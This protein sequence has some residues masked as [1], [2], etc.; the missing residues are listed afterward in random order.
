MSEVTQNDV[1]ILYG[2]ASPER[3]AV[4]AQKIA[5]N[6]NSETLSET[7]FELA[8][9]ICQKLADDI[10]ET[11]R[12]SLSQ[13]LKNSTDIPKELA[14]K[15]AQD[16]LDVSLPMLE[17]N[18]L[19]DDADLITLIKTGDVKRQL[20]IAH[21]PALSPN[22]THNLCSQGS[23]EVVDHALKNEGAQFIEQTYELVLQRFNQSAQIQSSMASR[24]ELPAQIIDQM[25]DLIS[26]QIKAHLLGTNDISPVQL[27]KMVLESREDAKQRFFQ[28]P[29]SKRDAQKLVIALDKQGKLSNE[30]IIRA[31][32]IGD[33]TFFEYGLAQRVK[34][35]VQNAQAL[36]K[37]K[38]EKGFKA[39]Y[40]QAAL[41]MAEFQAINYM[42]DVEYHSKKNRAITSPDDLCAQADEPESW[43]TQT[44]NKKK[45][46]RFF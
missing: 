9:A 7:E 37:D 1:K 28:N 32:E 39:L 34:I 18:E 40:T 27:E 19:L 29:L 15:L 26:D 6:M 38:G 12:C 33:R 35:P 4:L 44:A 45:K 24:A 11:V 46:W 23:E 10:D 16:V 3:R 31:L 14:L 17:F 30:L 13:A 22:V 36:I 5:Y 21:R 2:D 8:L 43:L 25:V 20:A 41:P 42:V